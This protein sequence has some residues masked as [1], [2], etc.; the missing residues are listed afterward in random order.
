M[1]FPRAFQSYIPRSHCVNSHVY[2]AVL[3]TKD[4]DTVVIRGRKSGKWS[5]PKGHGNAQEIPLDACVRELKEETGIDMKNVVPDEELRF[6]GGTYF[7][8]YLEQ[9][10]PLVPEDMKE[11]EEA[12]WVSIDRL[13]YLICNRDLVTFHHCVNADKLINKI[14]SARQLIICNAGS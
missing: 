7:V 1:A 5:F 8:Y 12:M 14:E 10:V 2:G 4:R 3:I 13:Q 11:V 6:R 9:R